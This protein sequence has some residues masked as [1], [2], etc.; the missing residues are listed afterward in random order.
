MR[1]TQ[2]HSVARLEP[3][4]VICKESWG[5]KCMRKMTCEVYLS[6]NSLC[7]LASI[8]STPASRQSFIKNATRMKCAGRGTARGQHMPKTGLNGKGD[9]SLAGSDHRC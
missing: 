9:P 4:S 3:C 2:T 8:D 6:T 1:A 7:L 5:V